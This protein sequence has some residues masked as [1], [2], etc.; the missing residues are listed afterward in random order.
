MT[1]NELPAGVTVRQQW[2]VHSDD[3]KVYRVAGH[4]RANAERE[5]ALLQRG[6]DDEPGEPGAA[7]A[8]RYVMDTPDETVATGWRW[9]ANW[10]PSAEVST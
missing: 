10:K 7:P 9:V 2:A 1:T 4:S 3:G 6:L 5:A 8:Y